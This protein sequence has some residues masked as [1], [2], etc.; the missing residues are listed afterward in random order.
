MVEQLVQDGVRI[1]A[2]SVAYFQGQLATYRMN[3]AS[4]GHRLKSHSLMF[5]RYHQR[6]AS[7]SHPKS[8][9]KDM[10]SIIRIVSAGC[11]NSGRATAI[12]HLLVSY[13]DSRQT[14]LSAL[15]AFPAYSLNEERSCPTLQW[16]DDRGVS[17]VAIFHFESPEHPSWIM[18]SGLRTPRCG[19][20]TSRI[21]F[22]VE[23]IPH[24]KILFGVAHH[25]LGLFEM[26]VSGAFYL[27]YGFSSDESQG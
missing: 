1:K 13:L 25:M 12:A 22:N 24:L 11:T 20:Q 21:D 8:V 3:P 2:H 17:S 27:W 19:W 9:P 5:E 16:T 18:H 26:P 6:L 14:R 7:L 4:L 23:D 10:L 15:C